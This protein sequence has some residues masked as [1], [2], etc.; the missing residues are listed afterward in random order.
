MNILLQDIVDMFS[1]EEKSKYTRVE[2]LNHGIY[3]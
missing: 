1:V 2:V 3:L